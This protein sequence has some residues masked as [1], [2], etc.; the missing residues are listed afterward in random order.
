MATMYAD[1]WRICRQDSIC[2][3]DGQ[4]AA[5]LQS[6]LAVQEQMAGALP[7]AGQNPQE[8]LLDHL[9]GNARVLLLSMGAFD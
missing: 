4:Y 8:R 6:W 7:A 1:T 3:C 5:P 2:I 9:I